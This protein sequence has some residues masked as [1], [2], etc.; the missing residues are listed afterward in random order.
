MSKLHFLVDEYGMNLT[1][2]L[3]NTIIKYPVSSLEVNPFSDHLKDKKIGYY[4][5]EKALFD[6]ITKETGA[7]K[8]RHPLTYIL[9]AA[10][11][12]AYKTADIEDAFVRFCF[13]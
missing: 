8:R 10:D 3:L 11:D 4:Y 1:Y 5:A 13:L 12:L 6:E 7:G 2:G 9:E